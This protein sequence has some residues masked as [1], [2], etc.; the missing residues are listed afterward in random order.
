M[1]TGYGFDGGENQSFLNLETNEVAT[2]AM[3]DEM[4]HVDRNGNI[5][6]DSIVTDESNSKMKKKSFF[7]RIFGKK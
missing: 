2:K 7:K 5:I 6:D 1:G 3:R 4:L